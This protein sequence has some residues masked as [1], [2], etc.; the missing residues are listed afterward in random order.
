[1][2]V[3]LPQSLVISEYFNYARF[4]EIVLVQPLAG[5]S[6]PFSGTAVDAP[7]AAGDATN[8][9]NSLSRITLDD[10]Q[11]APESARVRGIRT[12]SRSRSATGS[13]AATS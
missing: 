10:N 2:L 8:A 4:G 12:A 3:R 11:S 7:G 6:R 5:E 9:A 13:G 1:M